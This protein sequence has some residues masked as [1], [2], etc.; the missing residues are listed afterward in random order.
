MPSS[1]ISTALRYSPKP[2]FRISSYA[3]QTPY[4]PKKIQS[5]ITDERYKDL[6]KT[7]VFLFIFISPFLF[8]YYF[9]RFLKSLYKRV[10]KARKRVPH[11][12]GRVMHLVKGISVGAEFDKQ[13]ALCKALVVLSR[14]KAYRT[15]QRRIF[16]L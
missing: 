15:R 14:S 4:I 10:E 9:F 13:R 7:T 12:L 6:K 5:S 11:K 1:S 16:Y 8:M 3:R 2:V